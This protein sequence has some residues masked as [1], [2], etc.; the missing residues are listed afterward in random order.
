VPVADELRAAVN[1]F[2]GGD[3]LKPELT[4][5]LIGVAIALIAFAA[6]WLLVAAG[7]KSWDSKDR[8]LFMGRSPPVGVSSTT[9]ITGLPTKKVGPR[10]IDAKFAAWW[11]VCLAAAG[12]L[13]L[14]LADQTARWWLPLPA[15]VAAAL[16]IL[17][18]PA[19]A[20]WR[21]RTYNVAGPSEAYDHLSEL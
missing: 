18:V 6:A 7:W 5:E 19:I 17:L 3:T 20:R 9:P 15:L 4:G 2:V 1:K 14:D 21:D 10:V 13:V 11:L 12:A 16:L 8:R